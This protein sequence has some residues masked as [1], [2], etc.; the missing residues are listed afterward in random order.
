MWPVV[1]GQC[2]GVLTRYQ[3]FISVAGEVEGGTLT[4]HPLELHHPLLSQQAL[5]QLVH[6][7]YMRVALPAL[8]TVLGSS[9]VLGKQ[10]WQSWSS[11]HSDAEPEWLAPAWQAVNGSVLLHVFRYCCHTHTACQHRQLLMSKCWMSTET[12]VSRLICMLSSFRL[13]SVLFGPR[14]Q[15]QK[16]GLHKMPQAPPG[17]RWSPHRFGLRCKYFKQKLLLYIP[18]PYQDKYVVSG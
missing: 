6:S 1:F 4:L 7:H 8:L 5:I 16:A 17:G 9:N 13:F 14:I 10:Q 15:P 11:L 3:W 18:D 12:C 2:A